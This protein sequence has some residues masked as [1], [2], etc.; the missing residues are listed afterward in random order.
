MGLPVKSKLFS[1]ILHYR[2]LSPKLLSSA[3]QH[4]T[5]FHKNDIDRNHDKISCIG[6]ERRLI[7]SIDS[8][9]PG[10]SAELF[11]RRSPPIQPM[12]W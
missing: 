10:T 9:P 1:V 8:V 3:S 11:K 6:G 12:L 5:M 4:K 2:Y 7:H